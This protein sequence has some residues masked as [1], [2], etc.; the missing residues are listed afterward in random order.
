MRDSGG[1]S[2]PARNL[3]PLVVIVA[4]SAQALQVSTDNPLAAFVAFLA[5]EQVTARTAR[6]YLGHLH[7]FADWIGPRR[8][9]AA[10]RGWH[11][12]GC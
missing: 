2:Y 4:D 12:A 8:G 11:A 9:D 3:L 6:A 5:E 1:I 7:R 10:V